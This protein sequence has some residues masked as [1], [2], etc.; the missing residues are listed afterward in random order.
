MQRSSPRFASVLTV[1]CLVVV[2]ACSPFRGSDAR[3]SVLLVIVDTLRADHLGCYGGPEEP[4][5]NVDALAAEGVLFDRMLGHVPQTLPSF[6]SILTGTLPVTHGV[7]VNGMFALGEEAE[8]LAEVFRADGYRTGA[9]IAGFPLDARFGLDQGFQTYADEM[10]SDRAMRGLEREPDGS[11]EWLGHTTGAFENTADVVTDGALRWLEDVDGEPFFMLVHY[12]DPHHDYAPPEEF[13]GAFSH[14]YRGEVAFVD[15]QLG[16]LLE[17]LERRGLA[18]DTLVVFTADH[19]ECLGEH[20]RLNHV[21][22]L[23][24]AAVRVPFV[25]RAPG[26]LPEGVRV[27]GACRSVD[28]MPTI[29]EL[30]G[31]EAPATIEGSSLVAAAQRGR[32]EARPCYLESRYGALE[33]GVGGIAKEGLEYDGWKL[34]R[35]YRTNPESGAEEQAFELYDIAADPEELS[36]L[37]RERPERLAKL[38][39]RLARFLAEHPPGRA[40]PMTPDPEARQ[41]LEALGY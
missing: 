21:G 19:G 3:T 33:T 36:N 32:V 37:W 41:K 9:F 40:V 39:E 7:R 5:P 25:I 31:L 2:W 20:G 10:R 15:A 30:V 23:V 14:P 13:R 16:R 8:T 28:V 27:A 11:F 18:E 6:C 38:R 1:A 26:E 17:E 4:T 34:V 24:D 22:Q 12:F 29:L 35:T